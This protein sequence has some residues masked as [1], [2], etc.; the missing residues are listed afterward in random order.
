MRI[1]DHIVLG[2]SKPAR[3]QAAPTKLS[4]QR[5]NVLSCNGTLITQMTSINAD[6]TCQSVLA[7]T[8]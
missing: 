5:S 2:K 6:K 4:C 7:S 8:S 1:A 3:L